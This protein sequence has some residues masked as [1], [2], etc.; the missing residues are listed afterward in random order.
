MII[1]IAVLVLFAAVFILI[2]AQIY[3][4]FFNKKGFYDNDQTYDPEIKK[5]GDAAMSAVDGGKIRMHILINDAK[6]FD[7]KIATKTYAKF[8]NDSALAKRIFD[9]RGTKYNG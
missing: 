3:F 8:I 4:A 2:I 7:G 5:H 9:F 1:S 6:E